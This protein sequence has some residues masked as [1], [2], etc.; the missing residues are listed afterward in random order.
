MLSR[1]KIL[2]ADSVLNFKERDNA[3][4]WIGQMAV[5]VATIIGV[6]LASAEGLKSALTFHSA[7]EFEKRYHILKS[8]RE[9]FVMNNDKILEFCD[10]NF[11]L[12]EE[13]Q[14]RHNYQRIPERTFFV[15]D[16]MNR[17]QESLFLPSDILL[18]VSE[19]YKLFEHLADRYVKDREAIPGFEMRDLADKA[20]RELI[21]SMDAQIENY[22]KRFSHVQRSTSN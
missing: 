13:G 17:T 12:N 21:V 15:W 4:F 1:I 19:Y 22:K 9:E 5:I 14:M 3:R 6:F 8:L 20:K 18:G 2:L 7:T 11:F 16:L 10:K